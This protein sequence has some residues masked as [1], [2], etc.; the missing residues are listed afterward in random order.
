M[1]NPM[2]SLDWTIIAIYLLAVVGLGVAAAF[3]RRKNEKGGE[4]GHYFLAGNTL[5]WPG[6]RIGHVRGEYFYCS[7]RQSRGSGLQVRAGVRQF[8][9][10]GRRHCCADGVCDTLFYVSMI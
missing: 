3:L 9:V 6:H 8:R 7:S 4:G 1:N 2:S 10:D 5:A